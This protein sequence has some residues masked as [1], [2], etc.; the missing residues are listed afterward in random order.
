MIYRLMSQVWCF[1]YILELLLYI[2]LG[3]DNKKEGSIVYYS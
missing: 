1:R 2:L 3:Y